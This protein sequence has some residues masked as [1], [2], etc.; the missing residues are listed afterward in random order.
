MHIGAGRV[1]GIGIEFAGLDDDLG[2]GDGDATAGGRYGIEV[3]CGTAID[4]VAVDVG[5]PCFHQRK[6]GPKAALEDVLFATEGRSLLA[7]SDEGADAGAGV[8]AGDACAS[9][10]HAFSEGSLRGELHWQLAVQKLALEL[11]VLAHV[12]GDH[13]AYLA[14]L[15]QQAKS[16]AIDAGVIARNGQAAHAGSTEGLRQLLWNAAEAEASHGN[17]HAVAR[18]AVERFLRRSEQLVQKS[19]PSFRNGIRHRRSELLR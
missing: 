16:P 5:L 8:E 7:F 4:E 15:Q 3:A 18:D 10:A 6:V 2:L 13:L 9:R 12:A 14:R 17:Q 11:G 19:L 1:D